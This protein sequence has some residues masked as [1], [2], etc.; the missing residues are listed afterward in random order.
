[1]I[2]PARPEDLPAIAAIQRASPEA[3]SWDPS[4]YDVSVA[5]LEG[6]VVGFLVTRRIAVDEVEV[7]NVAV[8]PDR[9]RSGIARALLKPLLE[10]VRGRVFLEVR[11]SN[12]KARDF[13]VSVGFKEL[14]RRPGYYSDPPE[15]GIV[16]NFH[17]C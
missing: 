5:E 3:S 7:L 14:S 9:R 6:E 10:S 17:S 8:M 16:M 13:Y 15:P 2:R 4:G 11:E 12:R 1:M